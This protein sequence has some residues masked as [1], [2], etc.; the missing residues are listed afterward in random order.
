MKSIVFVAVVVV[1]ACA[2]DLQMTDYQMETMRY[3]KTTNWGSFILDYAQL[4]METEGVLGELVVAIR[5]LV[6]G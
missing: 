4:H 2:M 3:I 5:E 6:R 1:S